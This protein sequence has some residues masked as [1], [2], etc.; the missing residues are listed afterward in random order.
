VGVGRQYCGELGKQENCRIAVSLSVARRQASLPIAWRLYLP[1]VWPEVWA[2]D[3]D[4]RCIAKV[5]AEVTFQTKPE[6]ALAQIRAALAQS[7]PT[8]VVL[9]DGGLRP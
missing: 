7:V 6:I 4:R 1:E 5:P 8:G 3:P 9:A 2:N